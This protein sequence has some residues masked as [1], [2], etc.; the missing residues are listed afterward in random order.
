MAM[1]SEGALI[2]VIADEDT[3]TGFLLAGV[4]HVDLRK[5]TNYL[6]V[7][8][9]CGFACETQPSHSSFNGSCVLSWP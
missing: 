2:A 6:V 4:G 9:R 5:N 8:S 1:S 3:I 7:D